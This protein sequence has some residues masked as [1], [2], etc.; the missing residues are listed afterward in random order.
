M[1]TSFC[2]WHVARPAWLLYKH[3]L[4]HL[5]RRTP[6]HPPICVLLRY[7]FPRI[8][9]DYMH[10]QMLLFWL[11]RSSALH[12]CLSFIFNSQQ[13]HG[14]KLTHVLCAMSHSSECSDDA[15]CDDGDAGFDF[16]FFGVS[17]WQLPEN[18]D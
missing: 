8:S 18:I 2:A 13:V 7:P 14:Q 11:S 9:V 3:L 10:H 6:F 15:S 17:I 12:C 5:T 1:H 16:Q 4:A